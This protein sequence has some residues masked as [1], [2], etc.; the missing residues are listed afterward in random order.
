MTKLE[1][2]PPSPP[3][4]ADALAYQQW[5]D[6][7]LSLPKGAQERGVSVPTL[8]RTEEKRP[9]G[10]RIV[11]LSARRRGIRRRHALLLES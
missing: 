4:P 10:S 1:E 8:K 9:K 6:E 3:P 5:L 2:T 11:Q 7:M